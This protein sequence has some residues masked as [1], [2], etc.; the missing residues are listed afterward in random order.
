M[1]LKLEKLMLSVTD[2][3][4]MVGCKQFQKMNNTMCRVKWTQDSNLREI[5]VHAAGDLYQL[6]PVLQ[7]PVYT[8]P[9]SAHTPETTLSL[10]NGNLYS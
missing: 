3:I 2:E 10:W 9:N 4:S 1:Q 7:T 5:S 8:K 6:L